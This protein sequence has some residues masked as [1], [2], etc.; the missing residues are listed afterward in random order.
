MPLNLHD[1]LIQ[2]KIT[3]AV[4]AFVAICTTF[5]RLYVR[6]NRLWVDDA[7]AIFALLTV[8]AQIA[9]VFMHLEN[10]AEISHLSDIG[11]YY[12]LAVTFYTVIW[13]SRISIIYSIIRIDPNPKRR[14][15]YVGVSALYLLAVVIMIVQLFWVC[16][17][18]PHWKSARNPQCP[19]TIQVAV[20]Q[21]VTDILADLFLLLAPLRVF[22]H[23]QD[24]AL[25]RKLVIIFSTCIATTIVSLVH[26]AFILTTG[27]IKVIVSALVEDN[28]SLIVANV[29]VVVTAMMR[30]GS[31]QDK[32][33]P[34]SS[35]ITNTLQFAA[36]KLRIRKAR[37]AASGLTTTDL[38]S[39]TMG[40]VTVGTLGLYDDSRLGPDGST[41]SA[42]D[43]PIVLNLMSKSGKTSVIREDD[44]ERFAK[45]V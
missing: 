14:K 27:G 10:P 7:W 1:P 34:P 45:A 20:L 21:L 17:P 25:R 4:C 9:S 43:N 30:N 2:I 35:T 8:F 29:P 15:V 11:A 16:E 38:G 44:E 13:G 19:L 40:N 26:A 12:L 18:M 37:K 31:E 39:T 33:P 32:V 22:M 36:E 41:F 24:K 3:E 6:R 5:Y 23:L 42:H 28:I